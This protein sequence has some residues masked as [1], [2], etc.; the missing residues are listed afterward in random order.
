MDLVE[1][2]H[3]YNLFLTGINEH[4]FH[5]SDQ[6]DVQSTVGEDGNSMTQRT[7]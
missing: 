3:H 1:P 6:Q 7:G 5:F 4:V 2:F